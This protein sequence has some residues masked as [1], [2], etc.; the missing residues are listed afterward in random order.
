MVPHESGAFARKVQV[1]LARN[2]RVGAWGILD[3][4]S[5]PGQVGYPACINMDASPAYATTG[6]QS[7]ELAFKSCDAQ[8][9]S[10]ARFG[11]QATRESR[12]LPSLRPPRPFGV[13]PLFQ[14]RPTGP[15]GGSGRAIAGALWP[16]WRTTSC[17]APLQDSAGLPP[18]C[19]I[20][21]GVLPHHRRPLAA[22]SRTSGN[23]LSRRSSPKP[24]CRG[25]YG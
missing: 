17:C 25:L 22:P 24:S 4:S 15:L 5:S 7:S 13:A 19:V 3:A 6:H 11:G 1:P 20:L 18:S 21:G 10:L 23:F 14:F 12:L 9:S 16:L 8:R 2:C